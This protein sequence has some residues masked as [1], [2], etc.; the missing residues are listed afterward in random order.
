MIYSFLEVDDIANLKRIKFLTQIHAQ[1]LQP[2][3][4]KIKVK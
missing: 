1:I 4:T 2:E 3:I